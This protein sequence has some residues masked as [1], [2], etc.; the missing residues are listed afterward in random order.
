[1]LSKDQMSA[2]LKKMGLNRAY[3]PYC[4]GDRDTIMLETRRFEIKD[5]TMKGSQIDIYDAGTV[6]VW[7]SQKSKA[8]ALARAGGFKVRLFDGEAELYLPAEKADMYLH[9]LGAKVKKQ[10]SPERLVALA[11]ARELMTP[12][13]R[14][15][16]LAG[17]AA[18]RKAKKAL[19]A[20]P[21]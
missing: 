17:L 1:M 4:D 6:R 2:T 16:G 3:K 8:M 14:A 19:V 18:A 5:G 10:L 13:Q 11:K 20:T 21:A 9:S 12:E 7:T 15:K